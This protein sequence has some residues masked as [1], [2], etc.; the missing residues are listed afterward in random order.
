M[1]FLLDFPK[2]ALWLSGGLGPFTEAVWNVLRLSQHGL[3][4]GEVGRA[5]ARDE[6]GFAGARN[7]G[8]AEIFVV[9]PGWKSTDLLLKTRFFS[10]ETATSS[11]KFRPVLGKKCSYHGFNCFNH[12]PSPIWP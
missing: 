1:G 7:Q 9:S 10:G 8:E 5:S 6:I 2:K 12:Q 3:V 4:E 11:P